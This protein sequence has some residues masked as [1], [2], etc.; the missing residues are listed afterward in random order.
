MQYLFYSLIGGVV[1]AMGI[2]AG[3]HWRRHFQRWNRKL[4]GRTGVSLG[5]LFVLLLVWMAWAGVAWYTFPS[6]GKIDPSNIYGFAVIIVTGSLAFFSCLFV[7]LAVM[8]RP[9][10]RSS[11]FKRP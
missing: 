9:N 10:R 2:A 3:L 5:A 4:W 1:L 6:S 8:N 11:P 7:T